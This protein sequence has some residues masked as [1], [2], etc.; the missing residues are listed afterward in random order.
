MME[1]TVFWWNSLRHEGLLLDQ[2]RLGDLQALFEGKDKAMPSSWLCEKLRLK[3]SQSNEQEGNQGE[4]IGLVLNTTC[5]FDQNFTLLKGSEVASKWSCTLPDLKENIKPNWLYLE[6]ERPALPVFIDKDTKHRLGQGRGR[7]YYSK[8]LR[9]LRAFHTPL[10]LLTNGRQWRLIYASLDHEAYCEWDSETWF[11]NGETTPEFCGF[12]QFF[13]PEIW[14]VK[15][16]KPSRLHAAVQ[17]SRKGQNDLSSQM[18]ERV[19]QAVELLI[20]EH[21]EALGEL[22]DEVDAKSIY[23][24]GV[25]MVMRLVVVF[26]AESREGLLPKSNAVYSQN[27]SLGGLIQQLKRHRGNREA[28]A[29]SYH[30]WPRLLALM[31]LIYTGSS[32]EAMPVAPYGGKLFAPGNP[33]SRNAVDK[34]IA[35]FE[36]EWRNQSRPVMSDT[37]V[38]D[39]L[40]MLAETRVRICQQRQFITVPMPIDFSSLGNEYI[41]I[42]FES[43]LNFELKRAEADNPIVFVNVGD[44]PALPLNKLEQMSDKELSDMFKKFNKAAQKARKLETSDDDND[45]EENDEEEE[46]AEEAEEDNEQ[47]VNEDETGENENDDADDVIDLARQ[48]SVEWAKRACKVAKIVRLPKKRNQ[49]TLTKYDEELAREAKRLVSIIVEPGQWYLV[50]WGGTRKGSGTFYTKPQL[51]VPT[52]ERTLAPLVHDEHGNWRTPQEILALKVCDPACGSGSFL[53]ASLRYLTNAL[54]DSILAHHRL[55]NQDLRNIQDIISGVPSEDVLSTEQLPCRPEDD[56]FE[57][58]FKAILRRHLVENCI[59]GVDLDA[60]AVELCR[61]ALWIETMDRTLPMTFL[62]HK[63]KCGNSLVGAWSDQFLHYPLAAWIR[64]GGDKGHDGVHFA[65]GVWT[66][67][68]GERLKETKAQIIDQLDNTLPFMQTMS[69]EDVLSRMEALRQTMAKLHS[70]KAVDVAEQAKLY[71][72]MRGSDEY[73]ALRQSFDLWCALWFWPGEKLDL[74]LMPNDFALERLS[75]EQMETLLSIAGDNHFFHWELEFP[76]VFGQERFGFDAI[77]GNPPWDI[78]KPK[79]QEYF[80]N[81]DPLFRTYGKQV[82]ED[83][84]KEYFSNAKEVEEG[85]L[86]YCA[87]F[88]SMSNWVK[89]CAFPFGDRLVKDKKTG[90]DNFEIS[91]GKKSER[92]H[93]LWKNKR[94]KCGEHPFSRQGGGD[95]NLYKLFLEQAYSLVKTKGRIGFIVPSGIYSDNGTKELRELFFDKCSLEWLFSFENRKKI[96]DIHRSFKFNPLVIQKGGHTESFRA[97]FMRQDINDWENAEQFA[98]DYPVKEIKRFSPESLSVLEISGDKD[99]SILSKIYEH[100]ILLGDESGQG[101]GISISNEFHMTNDS[102][103]FPP[104]D[105]WREWGYEPDE[106]SRWIKGPW[107]PVE[108]L[109]ELPEV[110]SHVHALAVVAQPPYNTLRVKR[111]D[112]PVGVILSRDCTKWLRYDEIPDVKFTEANGKVITYKIGTGKNA[113]VHEIV[114][115]AIALPLYEGCMITHYDFSYQKYLRGTGNKS[116]WEDVPWEHKHIYSHYLMGENVYTILGGNDSKLAFR[117]IGCSTNKRTLSCSHLVYRALGRN[118]DKRTLYCSLLSHTASGNSLAVLKVHNITSLNLLGCCLNSLVFDNCLRYRMC[119]TN[120]SKF[121]MKECPVLSAQTLRVLNK[122][123]TGLNYCDKTF[124]QVNEGEP[125]FSLTRYERLRLMVISDAVIAKLY[126][127]NEEDYRFVLAECDYPADML[128]NKK[129]AAGLN[130][131]GF[132]RVDREVE[133]EL[134]QTVL[135]LVAFMELEKVIAAHGGDVQ[136]GIAAFLK[137]ND[138]EGWMLPEALTLAD[139]GLGHDERAKSPQPVASRLGPRF[140]DWQEAQPPEEFKRECAIHAANLALGTR[141]MV[142]TISPTQDNRRGDSVGTST[143]LIQQ[144]FD[145]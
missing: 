121:I 114:G 9:W 138:G 91:F 69:S 109:Y 56:D 29:T 107:K 124:A 51:A 110:R 86:H 12:L 139:Y 97:A 72:T 61:L 126:G 34:V 67:E 100:S 145:F 132:W 113:H 144:E 129:F 131:K 83:K 88:K 58:R 87:A 127:L 70:L 142:T 39:I 94:G 32:H 25:R 117:A 106:Y 135:S 118:T 74:A 23:M 40:V 111:C 122:I 41:G 3:L 42:L 4:N 125:R 112:L 84:Q 89:H 140:Y 59:Y 31:K 128:S 134:R 95:I 102:H 116:E 57:P 6:I 80:S 62:D 19:R 17:D 101:W 54:Y 38:L 18:G 65:N 30:A 24:A 22:G 92:Y 37:D 49:A 120:I 5:H 119:G 130:P 82:A 27:Y 50:R 53:L 28:L 11:A 55:E 52:V 43:L 7:G 33:A 35:L 81:V 14:K 2:T 141:Q 76:E 75:P 79:S 99:L 36:N 66:K 20:R 78:S 63:V 48:R 44:Q 136:A 13:L 71:E 98:L 15:D 46:I 115:K 85:W 105:T 103:L 16:G 45:V 93:L 90:M 104:Q 123:A 143:G 133:P 64:E 73:Q 21:G 10:G 60:V 108:E 77:L 8:V 1:A 68:I 26:F 137:Q 47:N 96:F